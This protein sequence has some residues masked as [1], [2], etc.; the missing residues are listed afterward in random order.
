MDWMEGQA[1]CRAGRVEK[2]K[3]EVERSRLVAKRNSRG[4]MAGAG[5][6]TVAQVKAEA[7]AG[8]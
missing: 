7:G 1:D 5:G 4:S 6:G 8:L 3:P 2:S